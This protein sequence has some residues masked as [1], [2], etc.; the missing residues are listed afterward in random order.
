MRDR[1]K[2]VT[3]RGAD[4]VAIGMGRPEM[5]ADFRAKQKMPFRLLVDHTKETYRTLE[6]G[7]ASLMQILGP[8]V[9]W[10]FA[11]GMVTGHGVT[12]PKQDPYQ[13][14]GAAVVDAGGRVKL[15]HRATSSAD[16]LPVDKLLSALG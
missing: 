2:E 15:V 3:D 5:A 10:R 14:S 16:N 1:Y 13:L 4:V 11:K 9:W 8:S 7:R 12:A 6:L